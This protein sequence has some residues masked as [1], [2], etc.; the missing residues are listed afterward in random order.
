MTSFT[1]S[2]VSVNVKNETAFGPHKNANGDPN[3]EEA[4]WL[5]KRNGKYY[6]EYAAGGVP[7]KTF[8]TC[9]DVRQTVQI[10]A[11]PSTSL[12]VKK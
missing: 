6:L 5:Y 4:S 7:T 9:R 12:M 2:E 1:G 10:T 3:F 8:T 11:I